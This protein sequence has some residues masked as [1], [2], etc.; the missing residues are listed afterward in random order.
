MKANNDAG[1]TL[2]EWLI[3]A[4]IIGII[5][6]VAVPAFLRERVAGNEASAMESIRA[7][8]SAQVT[9]AAR[10]GGGFYAPSLANLAR[11]PTIAGGDGFIGPDL[12]TDPSLKSGGGCAGL[13]QRC[14]GRRGGFDLLRGGKPNSR[15]RRP[16]LRVEPGWHHLPVDDR[17]GGDP[18][19]STGRGDTR[20]VSSAEVRMPLQPGV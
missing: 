15:G 5:A 13:V 2:I 11:S 3:V 12:G 17:G 4:A 7:I 8:N 20:T 9:Y 6:A 19:W 1:F 18:G 14:G 16:V 10:C